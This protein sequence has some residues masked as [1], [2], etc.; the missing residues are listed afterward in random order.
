MWSEG[1]PGPPWA[2]G[3]AKDPVE[4]WAD[5]PAG[6]PPT[7]SPEFRKWNQSDGVWGEVPG[8]HVCLTDCCGNGPAVGVREG[9][10]VLHHI[11]TLNSHPPPRPPHP[12]RKEQGLCPARPTGEEKHV[13]VK[14]PTEWGCW[15]LRKTGVILTWQC[16]WGTRADTDLP[17]LGA[18]HCGKGQA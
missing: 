15:F 4:V 14:E 2:L 3:V 10:H 1:S 13:T 17:F 9:L 18:G 6:F 12:G 16:N 5:H 8:G 11:S 7:R